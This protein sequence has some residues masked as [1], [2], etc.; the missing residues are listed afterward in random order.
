MLVKILIVFFCLLLIYQSFLA[1]KE[2]FQEASQYQSYNTN[3]PNDKNGAMI[4]GQQNAGNIE[5]L[6]QQI[7]ALSGLEKEVKNTSSNVEEL[8]TQVIALTQQQKE[9]ATQMVGTEPVQ[10]SGIEPDSTTAMAPF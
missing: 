4:L 1:L 9:A 3:D 10:V 5:Y 8:N 6:K 2:G 7:S